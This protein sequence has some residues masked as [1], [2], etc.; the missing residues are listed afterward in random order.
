MKHRIRNRIRNRKKQIKLLAAAGVSLGLSAMSA[1]AQQAVDTELLLLVDVSGSVDSSEYTLMMNGYVDAFNSGSMVDEIQGG[2]IG[3][4]AVGLMFWS[5]AAD[6]SLDVAW[7]HVYDQA[8]SEAF[9]DLIEATTRPFSGSTAIGSAL[10]AGTASFGTETGGLV[11]NGFTSNAQI[12]D[13]SGDGE[14]NATPPEGDRA[15]NV[16]N[17]RDAAIAAG[18][19]MINALPIGNAG[20]ALN[21]Y[22]IDNV[23]AGSSGGVEAFTQVTTT[24]SD[25]SASLQQK[26]ASEVAAGADI[27]RVSAVPEPS[28]TFLIG[29]SGMLFILRRKR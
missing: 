8:S 24:F 12:I 16:R 23:I 7:T 28:S 26:I 20:G 11:E 9:A 14:D 2:D 13:V 25:V 3:G 17:A 10:D 27:N 19:D 1:V 18:V 29:M 6:Q 22:F 15:L 5:G 21:Q 4:I